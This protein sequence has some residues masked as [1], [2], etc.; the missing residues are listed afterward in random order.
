MNMM[1]V[2]QSDI[3]S[4]VHYWFV[5]FLYWW[6]VAQSE[7]VAQIGILTLLTLMV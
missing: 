5:L 3:D 2:A 6:K 4:I 7:R 1:L